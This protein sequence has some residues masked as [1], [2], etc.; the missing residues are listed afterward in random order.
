MSKQSCFD[1]MGLLANTL[2]TLFLTKSVRTK[3][4]WSNRIVGKYIIHL[5]HLSSH[6]NIS[7]KTKLVRPNEIEDLWFQ[8]IAFLLDVTDN[9][10]NPSSK[11]V[12]LV[13]GKAIVW[14]NRP[15]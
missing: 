12:M 14:I 9:R 13:D 2:S 10:M 3:L 7:A 11:Y 1:L 8:F 6:N 15:A 4:F 5:I